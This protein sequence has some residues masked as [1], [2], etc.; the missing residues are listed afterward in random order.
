M[1]DAAMVRDVTRCSIEL[2]HKIKS[3]CNF[4]T[5]AATSL[6]ICSRLLPKHLQDLKDAWATVEIKPAS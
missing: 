3:D 1:R 2:R 4:A 6:E 5:F